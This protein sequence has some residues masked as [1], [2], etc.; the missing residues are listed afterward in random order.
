M[1]C[2]SFLQD[3]PAKNLKSDFL[4]MVDEAKQLPSKSPLHLKASEGDLT[5]IIAM[6]ESGHNPLDKDKDGNSALH[7]AA[8]NGQLNVVEYF[9]SELGCNPADPGNK[10]NTSLHFAALGGHLA[11][12]QYLLSD[13]G[14][15]ALCQTDRGITPL[16]YACFLGYSDIV[17]ELV[18]SISQYLHDQDCNAVCA[19]AEKITPLHLAAA[20]GH[21]SIIKYLTLDKKSDPMFRDLDGSMALH[22]AAGKGHLNVVKFLTSGRFSH[23][24]LARDGE[25]KTPLHLLLLSKAISTC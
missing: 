17:M 9:V 21:L 3:F 16:H 11:I 22:T 6:K 24:L 20:G 13:G 1:T 8:R 18:Q 4:K 2:C 25:G 14:V 7:Y 19:N 15:E 5:S 10:G 23:N 12:V